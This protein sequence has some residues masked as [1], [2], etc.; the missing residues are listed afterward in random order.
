[1]P[2]TLNA[3]LVVVQGM[4]EGQLFHIRI[5]KCWLCTTVAHQVNEVWVTESVIM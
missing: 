3:H 4:K 2:S 5:Y 1:M